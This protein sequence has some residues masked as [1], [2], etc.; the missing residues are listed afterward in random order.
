MNR[1][2]SRA[3]AMMEAAR[4]TKSWHEGYEAGQKRLPFR[5]LQKDWTPLRKFQPAF[6][7]MGYR[8]A[9]HD[10]FKKKT[11]GDSPHD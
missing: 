2:R 10:Y 7:E 8:E 5:T 3:E 11:E 1:N 9:R 6:W 4:A